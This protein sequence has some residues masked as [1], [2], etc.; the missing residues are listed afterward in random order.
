MQS[1]L[2]NN[3]QME[4]EFFETMAPSLDI[5]ADF[6]W[7]SCHKFCVDDMLTTRTRISGT[8]FLLGRPK[9]AIQTTTKCHLTTSNH[10]PSL[11]KP[12]QD[13][14]CLDVKPGRFVDNSQQYKLS[15]LRP[16]N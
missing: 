7:V 1:S 15:K 16:T 9:R 8:N 4:D 13:L 12:L 10:S 2:E 6:N 3:V 5:P 11:D 14:R